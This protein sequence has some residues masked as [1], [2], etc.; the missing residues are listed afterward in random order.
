MKSSFRSKVLAGLILLGCSWGIGWERFHTYWEPQQPEITTYA[1]I[2]HE[3]LKGRAL[4]SDLWDHHP[5]AIYFSYAFSEALAGYGPYSIF[6]LNLLTAFATLGAIFNVGFLYGGIAAGLWGAAIW[7]LISGDMLLWANQPY[8]EAFLNALLSWVLTLLIWKKNKG[9]DQIK[10]K[11]AGFLLFLG[12]LY[13]FSVFWFALLLA[14]VHLGMNRKNEKEKIT[15]LK[16]ALWL[17]GIPLAG[18]IVVFIYF[19][20]LGK[21]EDFWGAVFSYH[22]YV[23]GKG[24][25]DWNFYKIWPSF[26]VVGTPFLLMAVTG[27][28]RKGIQNSRPWIWLM[29]YWVWVFFEVNG[30]T[31]ETPVSYQTWLP[32]LVIGGAWG[33][34][35]LADW[36]KTWAKTFAWT[37]GVLLLLFCFA[38]EWPFYQKWAVDWSRA[39]SGEKTVEIYDFAK[40]LDGLLKK[41]ENFYEW[42]GETQLYYTTRRYPPSGVF[43]SGPLSQGPLADRLSLR[44]VSDLESSKPDLFLF[45]R[46]AANGNWDR[47]PI[48]IYVETHYLPIRKIP[49]QGDMLFFARKGGSLETRLKML[50]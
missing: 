29:V 28:L 50:K 17:V 30:S 46:N 38:H 8:P 16:E 11:A 35:E 48:L 32:P 34:W 12:S 24:L 43:T 6:L 9:F 44:V 15:F 47:N 3:L 4:Y 14:V 37:P 27:F 40:N 21:F 41:N 26:M 33:I 13:E 36:F 23:I 42:G 45:N 39:K 19:L 20:F 31:P 10:W 1:I 18:W 7:T 22:Q 25:L 5:P 2:G 49:V